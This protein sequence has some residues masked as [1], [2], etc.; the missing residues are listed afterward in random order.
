MKK[1]FSA[2]FLVFNLSCFS[3]NSKWFV[4]F[5]AAPVIGG[6]AMSLKSEMRNQN[7]DDRSETTFVIYGNGITNYPRGSATSILVRGGKSIDAR[8]SL[9]FIVGVA[10]KAHVEGYRKDG[11][12]NGIF[13]LFAGTVGQSVSI[14][15][16]I[17]QATAGFMYPISDSKVKFGFGASAYIFSYSTFHQYIKA[18]NHTSVVP[19]AAFTL[20]AP[21]GKEKR[22]FGIDFLLDAN[23]AL[24]VKMKTAVNEGFRPGN[25]NMCSASV[26]L[27]FS[28]RRPNK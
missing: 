14:K 12:S 28:L 24:P 25:V 21:L 17:Y 6:P 18:G 27:G 9:Y 10:E 1:F 16:N 4:S 13:G 26:G 2:I 11:W 5:S 19:G 23:L 3:Q 20:R 7:F 8:K 22:L 15:Y